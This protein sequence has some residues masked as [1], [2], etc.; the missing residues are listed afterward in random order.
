MLFQEDLES[1]RLEPSPKA[2]SG[3]KAI[4]ED[5]LTPSGGRSSCGVCL[6]LGAPFF[7]GSP[8]LRVTARTG[9]STSSGVSSLPS[10]GSR[11]RASGTWCQRPGL[12]L[13]S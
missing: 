4:V 11:D 6:P 3:S 2:A 10:V 12:C 5:K 1:Q 9:T 7:L 13:S 8:V